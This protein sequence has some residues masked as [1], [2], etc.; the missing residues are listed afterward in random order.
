[1]SDLNNINTNILSTRVKHLFKTQK[2]PSKKLTNILK[3]IRN[4]LPLEIQDIKY[5]KKAYYRHQPKDN[6]QANLPF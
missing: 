3:K 1:M 6:K 2:H 5:L 4:K